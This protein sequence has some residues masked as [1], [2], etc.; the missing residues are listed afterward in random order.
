MLPRTQS[1][2]TKQRTRNSGS[3]HQKHFLAHQT[4]YEEDD[5]DDNV[6]ID[7][8]SF[9]DPWL[10]HI[11][12]EL[13][14]SSETKYSIMDELK[15]NDHDFISIPHFDF[16][17]IVTNS[18]KIRFSFSFNTSFSCVYRFFFD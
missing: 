3:F 18:M 7:P 8:K 13:Y 4:E 14:I 6:L 1:L 9:V 2:S 5:N 16:N 12:S 17:D 10:K 11:P 15:W